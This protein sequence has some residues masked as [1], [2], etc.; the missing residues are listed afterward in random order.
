MTGDSKSR[1]LGA[2]IKSFGG[3]Q[4][5]YVYNYTWNLQFSV[6][7]PLISFTTIFLIE[8]CF[9]FTTL[10]YSKPPSPPFTNI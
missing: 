8:K 10:T 1:L 2:E 9:D 4:H 5:I 3:M 6:V 7:L